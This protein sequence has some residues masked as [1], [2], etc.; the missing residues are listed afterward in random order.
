VL[1]QLERRLAAV[2]RR[3]A[4]EGLLRAGADPDRLAHALVAQYQGM[5]LLA[6]VSASSAAELGPALHELIA[7]NLGE[8][9]QDARAPSRL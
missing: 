8:G 6:K 2:C 4:A 5:I 1:D 9:S 3:L 7:A